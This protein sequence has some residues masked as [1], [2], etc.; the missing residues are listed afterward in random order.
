MPVLALIHAGPVCSHGQAATDGVVIECLA[1]TTTAVT[2][3]VV[4]NE[5]VYH[6]VIAAQNWCW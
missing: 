2:G 1:R 5:R 3:P 6:Y 4:A